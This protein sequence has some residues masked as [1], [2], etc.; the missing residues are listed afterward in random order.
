MQLGF[1]F[2]GL[3]QN[4]IAKIPLVLGYGT[5]S[6]D[7]NLAE[8]LDAVRECGRLGSARLLSCVGELAARGGDDPQL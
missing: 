8:G 5:I 3:Y 7:G 2:R 6:C 4:L 1:L